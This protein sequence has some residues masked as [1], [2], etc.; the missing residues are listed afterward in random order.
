[1]EMDRY[2][3]VKSDES[4]LFFNDNHVYK[5]KVHLNLPITL[6][7]FWKV[8]L[9][10]FHA[11]EKSRSKTEKALY[12]YSD[13]CKESVVHGE[14]K[15][16]LRRLEKNE[17]SEWDY[18]I[19]SPFYLPVRKRELKEFEIDIRLVDGTNPTFLHSPVCLTL[20]LKPYPFFNDYGS[21]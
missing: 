1:M 6:R 15:A 14:E 13:I 5:F 20:H 3:Y 17:S 18:I 2:I 7:G 8:A 19:Q 10:E 9:V 12:V 4:D 11:A 16:L 21:F